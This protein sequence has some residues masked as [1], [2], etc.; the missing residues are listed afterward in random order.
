[1]PNID[2]ETKIDTEL[3]SNF[4]YLNHCSEIKNK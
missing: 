4:V 1:M 3:T 2:K